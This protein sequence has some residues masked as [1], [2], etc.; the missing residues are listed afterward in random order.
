MKKM[1]GQASGSAQANYEAKVGA[2]GGYNF[3]AHVT[4]TGLD[5]HEG[6]KNKASYKA[7]TKPSVDTPDDDGSGDDDVGFSMFDQETS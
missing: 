4:I 1:S 5:E 3:N 7:P 2:E 6:W